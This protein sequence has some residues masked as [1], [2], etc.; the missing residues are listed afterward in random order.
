MLDGHKAHFWFSI[1][2]RSNAT[3]AYAE[4]AFIANIDGPIR[5]IRS[6]IGANSGLK[7][8]RTEIF[9]RG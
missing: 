8:Q 4:G 6:Y 1:C 5:A 7:T 3:F 9:Y 2:A